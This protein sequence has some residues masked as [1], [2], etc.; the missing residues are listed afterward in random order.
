MNHRLVKWVGLVLAIFLSVMFWQCKKK[1]EPER[2]LPRIEEANPEYGT[3][4]AKVVAV[5][6]R[7]S[8]VPPDTLMAGETLKERVGSALS[9]TR[10]IRVMLPPSEEAFSRAGLGADAL[11]YL[12][13][14]VR[15]GRLSVNAKL[16][17]PSQAVLWEG[18]V[19]GPV[20]DIETLSLELA[21]N[22]ASG[23][24]CSGPIAASVMRII[25]TDVPITWMDG[26]AS[27]SVRTWERTDDAVRLFKHALRFD[28]SYAPA[29]AG[30]AGAYLL[31]LNERWND[32]LVWLE[33]AKDA[34]LRAIKHDPDMPEAR[35]ALGQVYLGWG[36]T[37]DAK[38]CFWQALAASPSLAEAWAGL[39]R[40]H[41]LNGDSDSAL[42]CYRTA[43]AV[44]PWMLDAA[45]SQTML[46][47][48]ERDYS[49]A[50]GTME[51]A[52]RIDPDLP[53]LKTFLGLVLFYEGKLDESLRQVRIGIGSARYGTLGHA[54]LAMILLKLD[55]Q[56]DALGE[57]ELEVKPRVGNDPGLAA[58]V[59]DVY[60][61]LKRPGEAIEWLKRAR[62]L[63]FSDLRWIEKDPNLD[64]LRGDGRFKDLMKEW[65]AEVKKSRS[66]Q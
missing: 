49:A 65:K 29:W 59:A 53:G 17:A 13:T 4:W 41:D 44:N 39:G 35:V 62:T 14:D 3:K 28:S 51:R 27:L 9:K 8:A 30:L 7:S 21:R 55:R 16:V 56:D 23:L 22:A 6:Q 47:L 24:G 1:T 52:I 66:G 11:F 20:W 31:I 46:Q 61:L 37:R 12:E 18:S 45:V 5:F 26:R 63:G 54:V 57:L 60:A 58:A 25:S 36:D 38:S 32:N 40:A 50:R 34:A 43:L 2:S 19:E 42:V 15:G 33:L 48:T 64:A 10:S